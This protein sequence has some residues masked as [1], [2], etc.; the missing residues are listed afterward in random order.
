[1][2]HCK[3]LAVPGTPDN[4]HSAPRAAADGRPAA[5]GVM[6]AA[7]GQQV[8]PPRAG[9]GARRAPLPRQSRELPCCLVVPA[10]VQ[11]RDGGK[12]EGW[13][14]APV[15]SPA[16]RGRAWA[17]AGAVV[18]W[19]MCR[20]QCR[21]GQS[22]PVQSPLPGATALSAS[23]RACR[24]RPLQRARRPPPRPLPRSRRAPRA[25]SPQCSPPLPLL[26]AVPGMPTP[27]RRRRQMGGQQPWAAFGQQVAPPR[28]GPG[29]RRAPLPRQ[30]RELPRCLVVP[31]GVRL[32]DGGKL[33]G[34]PPAPVGSPAQ[35]GRA[36][37]QAGAACL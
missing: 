24:A 6:R 31:A 32:R 4:P 29:A 36:W 8:A 21:V 28:A 5:L 27:P 7:F 3:G 33:E 2:G 16:Q 23:G 26:K 19:P 37:A 10:G 1:M 20:C 9:P 34:W 12:L 17:Q 30:S 35:R 14:P 18:T 15:G 11:L 13:L 25:A 22:P